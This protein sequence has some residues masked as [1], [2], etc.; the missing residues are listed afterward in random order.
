MMH[1]ELSTTAT[2]VSYGILKRSTVRVTVRGICNGARAKVS[3][4]QVRRC[5]P[6]EA[7]KRCALRYRTTKICHLTQT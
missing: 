1:I 3:S 5:Q 2:I 4:K 7:V 6:D